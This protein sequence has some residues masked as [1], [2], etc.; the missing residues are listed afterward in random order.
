[1]NKKQEDPPAVE[2]Q[3]P[4]DRFAEAIR[5]ILSVPKSEVEEKIAERHAA[6]K[7]RSTNKSKSQE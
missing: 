5:A 1:M 4:G 6:R 2:E 7:P 3:S